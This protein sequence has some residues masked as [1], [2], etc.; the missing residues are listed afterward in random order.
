VL[1]LLHEDRHTPAL[2][3]TT[4]QS[5]ARHFRLSFHNRKRQNARFPPR[6]PVHYGASARSLPETPP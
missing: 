4:V 2:E 1:N 6:R 5:L 3:L